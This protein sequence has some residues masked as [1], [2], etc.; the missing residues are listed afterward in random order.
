[1]RTVLLSLALCCITLRSGMAASPLDTPQEAGPVV[2]NSIG[3]K[4]VTI[5][6]GHFIMGAPESDT[7]AIG[8][9]SPQHTVVLSDPFQ[10]G[11]YEVTQE[12][13]E[14]VME[15]NPSRFKGA[16]HPVENVRWIDAVEFCRKLSALEAEKKAG[17]LYHLP[18][19]A[20][21]EYACR[22]GTRTLYSFGDDPAELGEYAWIHQ[23][24]RGSTHPV[25][26]KKA[27][28][29]GLYD[30]HG[31]V[32]EWCR[33]HVYRYGRYEFGRK[34]QTGVFE[35]WVDKPGNR[36][37]YRS[38]SWAQQ[39]RHARSSFRMMSSGGDSAL[40]SQNHKGTFG[41]RVIRLKHGQ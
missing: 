22:A 7:Q 11:M 23:N 16:N 34:I 40:R 4:F 26:E 36:V 10:L 18:S 19:E 33:G 5:P 31:N 14:R 37:V 38:G 15:T 8:A 17:Y 20:E 2:T 1:M 24:S 27:N 32:R 21:W 30:M 41:L 25:G 3:M 12:Q 29:W 9:E 13:Y 6:A 28:P 39:P 35:P